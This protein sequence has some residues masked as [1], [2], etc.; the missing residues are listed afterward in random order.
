MTQETLFVL[1]PLL[2]LAVNVLV[3]VAGIRLTRQ[4]WPHLVL[5]AGFMV[6]GAGCAIASLLLP[7]LQGVANAPTADV[8]AVAL[9]NLT[10]YAALSYGY[11]AFANLTITSLRIR[12]LQDL[13]EC[14]GPLPVSALLESYNASAV[15][16]ARLQ[17]LT[18]AQQ[19]QESDGRYVAG[20][21][22]FLSLA[23]VLDSLRMLVFGRS[24]RTDTD[25][26]QG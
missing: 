24:R 23:F 3:H 9:L 17:R 26:N 2:A 10:T 1:L 4:R 5:L 21:S 20:N 7:R 14:E 19:I 12:L 8:W 11:F 15:L 6:G 25:L 18:A 16:D 22:T 13:D